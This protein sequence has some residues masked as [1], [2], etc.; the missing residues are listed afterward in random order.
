M[1]TQVK[2]A[3]ST[4][5]CQQRS[6]LPNASMVQHETSAQ[7]VSVEGQAVHALKVNVRFMLWMAGHPAATANLLPTLLPVP[8]LPLL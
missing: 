1:L 6:D 3:P 5:P 2:D 8:L 7:Q 4:R